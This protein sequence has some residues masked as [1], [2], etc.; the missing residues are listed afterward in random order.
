MGNCVKVECV[1]F[2]TRDKWLRCLFTLWKQAWPPGSPSFS[3]LSCY[4]IW[5]AY[6]TPSSK[7]LQR[8]G[9][10]FS[11]CLSLYNST[12]L[13]TCPFCLLFCV[14]PLLP[15]LS[16]PFSLPPSPSWL[17]SWPLWAHPDDPASGCALPH[18]HNKRSPPP[19]IGSVMQFL[20]V[21]FLYSICKCYI[22]LCSRFK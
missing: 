2:Q 10:A 16:S 17:G 21:C 14:S 4:R 13:V 18:I 15:P 12:I 20:F 1:S 19:Y 11:S 6:P 3:Q 5:L 9:W 8:R 22:I 7:L